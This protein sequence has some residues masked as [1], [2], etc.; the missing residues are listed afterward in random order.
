MAQYLSEDSVKSFLPHLKDDMD[1]S[2]LSTETQSAKLRPRPGDLALICSSSKSHSD[3]LSS[4]VGEEDEGLSGRSGSV[5]NCSSGQ[6]AIKRM[7]SFASEWDEIERIMDLIGADIK[8]AKTSPASGNRQLAITNH[9][10]F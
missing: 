7:P 8:S 9:S 1:S 6:T 10:T 3:L 4:P 2:E 5:S